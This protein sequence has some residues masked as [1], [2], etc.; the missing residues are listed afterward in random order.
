MSDQYVGE[1]RMFAGEYAPVG[2]EFCNGQTLQINGYE[3]LYSVIGV[4]YGGNGTDNFK[5]PDLRGR[6]PLHY[7]TSKDR[8]GKN[9]STYTVGQTGGTETVTLTEAQLPKH[10]HLVKAHTAAGTSTTPAN[11]IWAT[12]TAKQ[13]SN[14][15][16]NGIMNNQAISS[17][18]GSKEHSNMMPFLP[19]TFIIAIQGMYPSQG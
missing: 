6:L 8:E 17:V 11:N 16:S 4:M 5:L 18:G 7:G 9:I 10:T 14:L 13:Y 2:W 19:L 1:I 15:N 12:S 3:A